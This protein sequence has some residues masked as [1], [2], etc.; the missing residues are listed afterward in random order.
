[1]SRK[2]IAKNFAVVIP[3]LLIT[4]LFSACSN[5]SSSSNH[6][7]PPSHYGQPQTIGTIKSADIIES[8][9][10]AASKCQNNV[11]WTHND[12]GDGPF[13]FAVNP[14]GDNL[15]T[16]KV[17]NAEN[18]DWEDIA[19]YKDASGQCF[20]YI[21]EI[22]DNKLKRSEQSVYRVKEPNIKADNA[23]SDSKHPLETEPAEIA[24]FKYPDVVQNAET[25]MVHPATGD[26]YVMTKRV[27]GPSG[28]YRL[29]PSFGGSDVA[30]L[31]KMADLAVPAI[32]N[33]FLTGGDISPDGRRVII[34][35]YTQG[36]ELVL[37]ETSTNFEDIWKQTPEV[38]ELGKR[39]HGESI[40]YSADGKA[41][42]AGSE[43]RN[44]PIIEL[45]RK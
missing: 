24:R 10:L 23:N 20:I 37:P 22:G 30:T 5:V 11:L 42:F 33:G 9:G 18:E 16:W 15:G 40:C 2:T 38:V 45:K 32:P 39:K 7:A 36:Y 12:S 25:L 21:G 29:H 28:V 34:C 8:S 6:S 17:K 19:E 27:N 4:I 44:S 13:I 31:E 26:I 35:D 1:M 43:G 41:V 14:A 3:S